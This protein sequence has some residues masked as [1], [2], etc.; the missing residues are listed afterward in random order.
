[1]FQQVHIVRQIINMSHCIILLHVFFSFISKNNNYLEEHL[2]NP[3]HKFLLVIFGFQNSSQG[4]LTFDHEYGK[5]T[6]NQ[7]GLN[8]FNLKPYKKSF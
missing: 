3:L 6:K 4:I 1:M 5:I 8:C 7:T 2:C